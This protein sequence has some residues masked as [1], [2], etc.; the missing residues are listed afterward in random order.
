[1][2]HEYL[3]RVGPR[4]DL[5]LPGTT[6]LS[7]TDRTISLTQ[8]PLSV[9]SAQ[10]NTRLVA[11]GDMGF[12]EASPLRTLVLFTDGEDTEGA[13]DP[14]TVVQV[15]HNSGV[16]VF[17]LVLGGA[18]CVTDVLIR[19]T[20]ANLGRC[21]DVTLD[22][23]NASFRDLFTLLWGER[24]AYLNHEADAPKRGHDGSSKSEAKR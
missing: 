19:V 1:V 10:V 7:D 21:Y 5:W 16:R 2:A 13:F 3:T 15:V 20:E 24:D 22:A 8:D 9:P 11:S 23:L 17:A 14:D 6:L 4:P 12:E 18:R